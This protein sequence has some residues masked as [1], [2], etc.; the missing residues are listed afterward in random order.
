MSNPVSVA[1][2]KSS[3]PPAPSLYPGSTETILGFFFS[4]YWLTG[5]SQARADPV[6][7]TD[8]YRQ[9]KTLLESALHRWAIDT[10]V[11]L[12]A[13]NHKGEHFS[14]QFDRMPMP[15]IGQSS[16]SFAL[17]TLEQAIDRCAMH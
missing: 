12:A 1:A 6:E 3:K 4:Q 5:E 15:S 16:F 14:T 9:S 13:L 11:G 10:R 8:T 2:A 17:H 7:L